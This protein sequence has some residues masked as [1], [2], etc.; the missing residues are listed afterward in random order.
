M[1]GSPV[2][3]LAVGIVAL[4]VAG[5]FLVAWRRMGAP[6]FLLFAV[7]LGLKGVGYALG[8][9]DE[10]VVAA[11]PATALETA[12][13]AIL[14]A[15][16]LIMVTAYLG[17]HGRRGWLAAGWGLA[18]AALV[19]AALDLLVP[20][21]GEIDLSILSPSLHGAV[22]L[23]NVACAVLAAQ[24]FAASPRPSRAL[25]PAAFLLWGLS[26]Y[27][28]LLIDL[29]APSGFGLWVQAWRLLAVLF[30]LAALVVPGRAPEVKPRAE[31]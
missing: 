15:G 24:G 3:D 11:R 28:W 13:L 31:A 9:P 21:L 12:R 18:G 4:L 14:F 1:I 10:F 25:V 5:W 19:L 26:N 20:P 17:G 2:L 16:N 7:G 8:G 30:M 22:A 29:G 27:T 6:A 23:A